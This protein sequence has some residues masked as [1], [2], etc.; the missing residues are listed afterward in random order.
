MIWIHPIDRISWISYTCLNLYLSYTA[1]DHKAARTQT[2]PPRGNRL[3]THPHPG[4]PVLLQ[5]LPRWVDAPSS[6]PDI[7]TPPTW[8]PHP[9]TRSAG[10]H[11]HSPGGAEDRGGVGSTCHY[12]QR[13]RGRYKS[14]GARSRGGSE[15]DVQTGAEVAFSAGEA[16]CCRHWHRC[17]WW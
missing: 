7:S 12:H 14:N 2:E 6:S 3:P 10:T 17:W 15:R 13:G 5:P 9:C 16:K 11:G 8:L 1:P 4:Q